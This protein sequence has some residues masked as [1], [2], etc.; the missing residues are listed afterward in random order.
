MWIEANAFVQTQNVRLT[1][2]SGYYSINVRE[3]TVCSFDIHLSTEFQ[4]Q[5]ET[6][7]CSNPICTLI[8]KA[9]AI[10]FTKARRMR[11]LWERYA[12]GITCYIGN[13]HFN[14]ISLILFSI[15]DSV[16]M[17]CIQHHLFTLIHST[18]LLSLFQLFFSICY[19]YSLPKIT[20]ACGFQS[21]LL[22]SS[23]LL[24]WKYTM[25]FV[26]Q[27]PNSVAFCVHLYCCNRDNEI[28]LLGAIFFDSFPLN[29]SHLNCQ[30]FIFNEDTTHV[31]L[32]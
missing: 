7:V 12:S 25:V 13:R 31:Q 24:T 23:F 28:H 14:V 27:I 10:N 20:F 22:F 9:T 32:I 3:C 17:H 15:Y 8:N 30:Y 26:F 4:F 5:D 29:Y 21:V 2:D 11:R 18:L 6:I 19:I 16:Y 1:H